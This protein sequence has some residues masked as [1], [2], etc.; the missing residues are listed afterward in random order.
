MTAWIAKSI[1][2]S[3]ICVLV[4]AHQPV[5]DTPSIG[6]SC[7]SETEEGLA[8]GA[9][10]QVSEIPGEAGR[11]YVTG[12]VPSTVGSVT[13]TLAD[14]STKTVPVNDNAW[15]LEVEGE[16]RSYTNNPVGG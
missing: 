7:S 14:G 2:G 4:W 8:H 1:G 13:A 5:G 9:T 10:A 16:P 3:G 6:A 15:S 12:V 11:V